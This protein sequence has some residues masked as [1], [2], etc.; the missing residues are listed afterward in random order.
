MKCTHIGIDERVQGSDERF[1]ATDSRQRP[2]LNA[3]VRCKFGNQMTSA[4]IHHG[5]HAQFPRGQVNVLHEC[6][7]N[8]QEGSV[9]VIDEDLHCHLGHPSVQHV[10]GN[11]LA[12]Y[13]LL[14]LLQRRQTTNG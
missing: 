5:L 3:R 8:L 2:N 12:C 10:T 4:L 14:G 1:I 13:H 6:I 7:G 11:A 9:R